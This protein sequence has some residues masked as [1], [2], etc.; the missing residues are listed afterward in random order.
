VTYIS[1]NHN[2]SEQQEFYYPSLASKPRSV[3][4]WFYWAVMWYLVMG[5]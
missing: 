1:T 4:S 5:F 3:G 2:F